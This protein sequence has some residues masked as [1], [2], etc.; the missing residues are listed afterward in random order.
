MELISSSASSAL[1][2]APVSESAISSIV[3]EPLIEADPG[4]FI[5][6]DSLLVG[7]Y[8]DGQWHNIDNRDISIADIL[9]QDAYYCYNQT[10]QIGV[11][12]KLTFDKWSVGE[13]GFNSLIPYAQKS[14]S[15][16]SEITFNIPIGIPQNLHNIA[17]ET[18]NPSIDFNFDFSSYSIPLVLSTDFNPLP[19]T[20]IKQINGSSEADK[21]AVKDELERLGIPGAPVNITECYD[22]DYDDDGITEHFIFAKTPRDEWGYAYV[23]PDEY[24]NDQS[25]Y[26]YMVLCKDQFGYKTVTSWC[27]PYLFSERAPY[28]RPDDTATQSIYM[29]GFF[30][31]NN[32]GIFEL[33]LEE[34]GW[35][36]GSVFVCSLN[37][38]NEWIQV[39]TGY[40][41]M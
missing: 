31:L 27:W 11:T 25:G 39:L 22:F 36:G 1:S 14:N 37:E 6:V 35:E 8:H 33:C 2:T 3:S 32:D 34:P 29:V 20:E 24:E 15:K 5:L 17:I 23:S 12:K 10:E 40:C 38:N 41:G 19:K 30:D 26:Y 18:Y 7:S 13:K 9:K 28:K 4:Y 21:A 16:E